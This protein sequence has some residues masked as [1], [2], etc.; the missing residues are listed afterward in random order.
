MTLDQVRE[1]L[2]ALKN[3]SD[4][5]TALKVLAAAGGGAKTLGDLKAELYGAVVAAAT[6]SPVA[7]QTEPDDPFAA[8]AAA[9]QEAVPTAEELKALVI[10]TGKR[11]SQ[12][13]VQ[14]VVMKHGGK[15]PDPAGG[16]EKPNFKALPVTAY[17]AV[18][19]EL[20]AL[21]STK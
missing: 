12:D 1:A 15:A 20:K 13:I 4:Q 8:P 6:R 3:R 11:T 9:A 18:A 16:P 21:P 5:A 2:V 10:A 14:K 7:A 19:A 17:L